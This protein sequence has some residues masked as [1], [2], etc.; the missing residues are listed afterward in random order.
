MSTDVLTL[1]HYAA[2]VRPAIHRLINAHIAGWL[3]SRPLDDAALD[4]W[5]T[6]GDAFQPAWMLLAMRGDEPRAFLHGEVMEA[7]LNIH[8]LALAPGAV[9]DGEWLL[10]QAKAR[11]RAAGLQRMVGPCYRAGY[12]YGSYILGAEPY[13]PQWA[14]DTTSAYIRA[15]LRISYPGVVMATA[16]NRPLTTPALPDGY[17]LAEASCETEFNAH[18]FRYVALS[19]D[20]EAATCTARVYPGLIGTSGGPVG[21]LGFVGTHEAHRS[22]GL[23]RLL[24]QHSLARLRDLGAAEAILGTGQQNYPALKA[25]ESVGFQRRFMINEWAKDF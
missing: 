20:E 17:T 10:G 14:L 3:Y 11:A 8:L 23:A 21:Q 19:G 15:G 6:L 4:R 16:L 25:Y 1:R 5:E 18:A 2:A 24:C 7:Q 13:T 12:F 22:R 9:E